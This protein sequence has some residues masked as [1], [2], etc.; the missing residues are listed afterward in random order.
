MTSFLKRLALTAL[1][2]KNEIPHKNL[3]NNTHSNYDLINDDTAF[4]L[5]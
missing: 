1:S 4:R 5:S 3:K 2:H